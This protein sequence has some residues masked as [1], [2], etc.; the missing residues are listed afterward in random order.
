M[1]KKAAA[2]K[3]GGDASKGATKAAGKLALASAAE[4]KKAAEAAEKKTKEEAYKWIRSL[5]PHGSTFTDAALRLAFTMAGLIKAD[6]KY[7]SLRVDTVVLL[8]DGAPTD[9]SFPAAKTMDFNV[10]LEHVRE[11]NKRKQ[12]VLHCI[13]VDMMAGNE[14]MQKL[15]ESAVPLEQ[16]RVALDQA[17]VAVEAVKGG[18][19]KH[20][21]IAD[22]AVKAA[23]ADIRRAYVRYEARGLAVVKKVA[24]TKLAVLNEQQRIL[25]EAKERV[26]DALE[27]QQWTVDPARSHPDALEATSALVPGLALLAKLRA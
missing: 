22:G 8:S 12:I 17:L 1:K 5:K 2:K 27:Y 6:A 14:F 20:K 3:V 23:A 18:I 25:R 7:E 11:W 21:E 26:V 15:A 10:I 24:D 4:T 19:K 9:N 13:A 16:Q